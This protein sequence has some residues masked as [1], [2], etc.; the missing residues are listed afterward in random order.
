MDKVQRAARCANAYRAFGFNPLPSREDVKGPALSGYKDYWDKPCPEDVYD[1]HATGNIQLVCGA[2]WG[3]AVVDLDGVLAIERWEDLCQGKPNPDTWTVVT[4][5]GGRHLYYRVPVGVEKVESRRVWGL[6]D[7]AQSC[8]HK[9]TAIEILGDHKLVIAP[10]STHVSTGL[11]YAFAPGRS[12]KDIHEP[13][14][15]PAWILFLPGISEP[16]GAAQPARRDPQPPQKPLQRHRT[17]QE[18]ISLVPD[19]IALAASWGLRISSRSE[20][21]NGWLKCYRAGTNEE[22]PSAGISSKTGQYWEAG[23]GQCSLFD[24]A[25]KLGAFATWQEAKRDTERRYGGTK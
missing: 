11:P 10:P 8:W 5:S 18:V 25:V 6:W 9:H 1:T 24:L 13:A 4:G 22:R 3:L 15:M 14:E 16:A 23:Q 20:S 2:R 21:Q 17:S 19:K 7:V 12:P